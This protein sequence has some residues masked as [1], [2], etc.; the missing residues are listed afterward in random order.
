MCRKFVSININNM[1]EM[2]LCKN[3]S[4]FL[5]K[6]DIEQTELKKFKEKKRDIVTDETLSIA[7]KFKDYKDVLSRIQLLNHDIKFMKSKVKKLKSELLMN[8]SPGYF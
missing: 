3:V 4:R 2:E 7:Q 5:H 6:I 8:T 1:A